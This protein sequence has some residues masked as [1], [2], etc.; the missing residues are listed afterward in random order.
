MF[1]KSSTWERIFRK[2]WTTF[3]VLSSPNSFSLLYSFFLSSCQNED[4]WT[5]QE[6][7]ISYPANWFSIWKNR[8]LLKKFHWHTL[9]GFY[10]IQAICSRLYEL[11]RR[12]LM[13]CFCIHINLGNV[14][15]S[16]LILN[17]DIDI[18]IMS[19]FEVQSKG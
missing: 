10:L 2:A 19:T 13:N 9:S 6:L 1:S 16:L 3:P 8:F 11:I 15:I 4:K 7:F 18:G 12:L 14:V 5:Q 17:L